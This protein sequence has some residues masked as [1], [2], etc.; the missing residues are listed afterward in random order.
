MISG[1]SARRR[2][3]P[4]CRSRTR[5]RATRGTGRPQQPRA[6][7]RTSRHGDGR[8]SPRRPAS[9]AR[10]SSFIAV[11]ITPGST[12]LTRTPS[13]PELIRRDACQRG[14]GAL[15][16]GVA[17]VPDRPT[18]RLV[19]ADVDDGAID[20]RL[21]AGLPRNRPDQT[22]GRSQVD[23]ERPVPR[24]EGVVEGEAA[25]EDPGGVD[26]DI[27]G[28]VARVDGGAEGGV[29]STGGGQVDGHDID[30]RR[31]SARR[32]ARRADG[33]NGRPRRPSPRSPEAGQRRGPADAGR[34]AGDEPRL[35]V[36]AVEVI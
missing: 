29:A 33:R 13:G 34:G 3:I 27:D 15:R 11:S 30:G 26:D 21:V 17:D 14:E 9:S 19:G 5:R 16:R 24:V 22:E 20:A 28:P 25:L 7:A 8:A 12:P 10:R 36:I 35:L 31:R 32:P 2:P 23:V 4:G 1:S 18:T 6:V